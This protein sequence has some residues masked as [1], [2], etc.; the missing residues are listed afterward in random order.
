MEGAGMGSAT[1]AGKMQGVN[2]QFLHSVIFT[3]LLV[4]WLPVVTTPLL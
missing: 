3:S 1:T 2:H 4:E